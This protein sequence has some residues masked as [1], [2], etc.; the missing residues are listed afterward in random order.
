MHEARILHHDVQIYD[1]QRLDATCWKFI[2]S[3]LRFIE[4]HFCATVAVGNMSKMALARRCQV[5]EGLS[6]DQR[7]HLWGLT[8]VALLARVQ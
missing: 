5:S 3:N 1:I 8:K 6:D 2:A 4:D 7:N